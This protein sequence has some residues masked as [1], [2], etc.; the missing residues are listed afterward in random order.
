MVENPGLLPGPS[1]SL[2]LERL[3]VQGRPPCPLATFTGVALHPELCLPLC[4]GPAAS[5]EQL[6]LA[7]IPGTL[8]GVCQWQLP[9]H[10]WEAGWEPGWEHGWELGARAPAG[11]SKWGRV[12]DFGPPSSLQQ[13]VQ[14]DPTFWDAAAD[15]HGV[16]GRGEEP[17]S[18]TQDAGGQ[19]GERDLLF[20]RSCFFFLTPVLYS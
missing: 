2:G 17:L 13:G 3:L 7:P 16:P 4:G 8:L 6:R 20:K 12:P 14:V 19:E 10:G 11:C 18:S 1:S 9:P 5:F 15:I